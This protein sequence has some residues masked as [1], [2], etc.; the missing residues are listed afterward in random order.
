M[1]FLQKIESIAPV[2][3]RNPVLQ[4]TTISDIDE[5]INLNPHKTQ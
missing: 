3:F 2:K 5:P 1:D 4:D